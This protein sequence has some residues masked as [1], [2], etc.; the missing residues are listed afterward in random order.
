S[1]SVFV[2]FIQWLKNLGISGLWTLDGDKG[3]KFYQNLNEEIVLPAFHLAREVYGEAKA[4][5]LCVVDGDQEQMK[6]FIHGDLLRRF[7]ALNI[8]VLK[9]AASCTGIEQPN[10]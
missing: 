6:A 7:V 5:G 3:V 2:A 1:S 9:L 10:D 8:D 4:S